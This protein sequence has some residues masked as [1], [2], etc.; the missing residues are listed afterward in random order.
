MM[1][2]W[3]TSR[4]TA[5]DK[6]DCESGTSRSTRLGRR[7]RRTGVSFKS[8]VTDGVFWSPRVDRT[9]GRVDVGDAM[10]VSTVA[11]G[12]NCGELGG[13]FVADIQPNARYER[14][15]NHEPFAFG[16]T[17]I[18]ELI[19]L[20]LELRSRIPPRGSRRAL[21]LPFTGIF[22]CAIR[23]RF[24]YRFV[25][26]FRYPRGDHVMSSSTSS[27]VRRC[28]SRSSVNRRCSERW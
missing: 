11:E 27:N 19:T 24:T 14:Q 26:R 12:R 8:N 9:S 25:V 13:T 16:V 5:D 2:N 18:V 22:G 7:P 21:A 4:R 23:H 17:P 10:R 1:A 20:K 15:S 3:L 6:R 28:R